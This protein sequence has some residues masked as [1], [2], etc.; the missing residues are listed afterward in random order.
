MSVNETANWIVAY[1]IADRRRGARVLKL[2]KAHGLPLQ[3]S[4]FLVVASGAAMH[5]LM[6]D[7]QRLIKPAVD[8]VRAYRVPANAECHW[9]G[10]SPLPEGAVVGAGL[11]LHR[12]PNPATGHPAAEREG[13]STR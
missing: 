13:A 3:Y 9:L 2:M 10:G 7:V 11:P 1:D 8:D 5:A 6:R 4:V 12:A